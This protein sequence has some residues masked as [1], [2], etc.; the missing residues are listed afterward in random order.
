M[1]NEKL[2]L[3][4]EEIGSVKTY[5]FD[6]YYRVRENQQGQIEIAH[7][8]PAG[9]GTTSVHPEITLEQNKNEEWIAVK[10]SDMG[11]SPLKF[12]DRTEVTSQEIDIELK[13]LIEKMTNAIKNK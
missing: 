11:V 2:M 4:K 10:L 1:T 6:G 8:V 9:C 3:L 5:I 7:L 12:L 13:L